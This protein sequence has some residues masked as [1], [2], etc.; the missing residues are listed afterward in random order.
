MSESATNRKK[1][2]AHQP[3]TKPPEAVPLTPQHTPDTGAEVTPQ[4]G[5]IHLQRTIGNRATQTLLQGSTLQRQLA[6]AKI[7][8]D[9]HDKGCNCANCSRVSLKRD[10]IQRVD[11]HEEDIQAKRDL[12]QRVDEH[13]EDI[14][15]M[16]VIQRAGDKKTSKQK[17]EEATLA[18]VEDIKALLAADH[19]KIMLNNSAMK[20]LAS[21]VTVKD[22]MAAV[23]DIEGITLKKELKAAFKYWSNVSLPDVQPNI[24]A[25][26]QDERTLA[27]KSSLLMKSARKNMGTDPYL[28]MLPLLGMFK[29]GKTAEDKKSHT[30]ADKADQ[31]IRKYLEPYV[32]EAVKAGKKVE[33]QVAVV[34]G[35]DWKDAYDREFG[36]DGLEDS[37]NAFV[38][39]QGLIWVH[40][41]RGNAGTIIH[42]GVHKYST[43]DF[44]SEV[45]F[46]FNEGITEY[47]TR[48]ITKELKYDRGNYQNNFE[49]SEKF[50]AYVGEAKLASGYFD[51]AWVA[52][53][54]EFESKSG[55]TWGDLKDK[56]KDSDWG[57]AEGLLK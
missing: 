14:Q 6:V 5:L 57:A 31:H 20:L 43:G 21:K 42:E 2:L 12:I 3:V 52:V 56:V 47:F 7:Q 22:F 53:K 18:T 25:A 15:A 39:K 13:E 54:D 11:E 27:W 55:E 23:K 26:S 50:A 36:N 28:N 33:G 34:D 29:K 16:R 48:K 49:F 19:K 37:T 41:T 51:G 9:A 10:L 38:D 24:E 35:K 32:G 4:Q 45:G 1:T 46:E 17:V 8:R 44:L 40:K 30:R